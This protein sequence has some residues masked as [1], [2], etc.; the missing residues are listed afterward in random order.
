M[1]GKMEIV[2]VNIVTY[3]G[4]EV[5]HSVLLQSISTTVFASGP[6]IASSGSAL[7]GG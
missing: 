7:R 3:I 6:L 4:T 2:A 5:P 1:H